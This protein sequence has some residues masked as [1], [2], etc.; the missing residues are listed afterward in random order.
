MSVYLCGCS[1]TPPTH[2]ENLC[3]IFQEKDDWYVAAH[4][5]HEKY[6]I[7]INVAM[8]IMAQESGFKDDAKPPMRWFLFIPYGRG[9]SSYGYAQAQDEVWSDYTSE[10]GGFFSSRDDFRDSLDFIG[11]YMTKTRR[12]NGVSF[13]DAYN[14]YLNYHEGWSGYKKQTYRGKDWLQNVANKV[15]KRAESYKQQLLKCNLY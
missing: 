3:S 14:Q 12:V 9:S 1:T 5:V 2:P 13:S 4:D 7:P 11:W 15:A 6:G 10:E 8:S